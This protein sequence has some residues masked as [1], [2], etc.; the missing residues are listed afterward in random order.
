MIQ[1]REKDCWIQPWIVSKFYIL[2]KNLLR[3]LFQRRVPSSSEFL[4][5]WSAITIG[6]SSVNLSDEKDWELMD[7]CVSQEPSTQVWILKTPTSGFT[8]PFTLLVKKTRP[9]MGQKNCCSRWSKRVKILFFLEVFTLLPS[10]SFL[11]NI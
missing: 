1:C 10:V 11:S 9:N 2:L 3:S 7:Q 5:F 4:S 6:Y 8:Y